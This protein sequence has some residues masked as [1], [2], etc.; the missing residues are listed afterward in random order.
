MAAM[1]TFLSVL[2]S[3]TPRERDLL[4]DL[5]RNQESDLLASRSE[6]ARVRLVNEFI[7]QVHESLPPHKK[8]T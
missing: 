7:R 2:D 6:E 1:D 4:Q 5:V 3:M 8:H